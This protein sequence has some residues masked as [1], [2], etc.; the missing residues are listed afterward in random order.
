M[1]LILGFVFSFCQLSESFVSQFAINKVQRKPA[2]HLYTV[3]QKENEST[4]AFLNRFMKEKMGVKDR[5]DSTACGAL[6]DELRSA[7]ILK[8]MISIKED[9]SYPKLISEIRC[10]IQVEKTSDSEASKLSQ[11]ILLGGK[12]KID[13]QT[14]PSKLEGNENESGKKNNVGNGNNG[15]PNR[16]QALQNNQVPRFR[17]Y[18]PTTVPVATI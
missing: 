11:D 5:N 12:C 1:T 9:I 2:W 15:N 8:Y 6:M 18:T 13:S 16:N 10:H 4:K 3:R 14:S 7:T 17:E